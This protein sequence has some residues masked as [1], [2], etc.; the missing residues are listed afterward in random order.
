AVAHPDCVADKKLPVATEPLAVS[1]GAPT[2]PSLSQTPTT[3]FTAR[4]VT[5]APSDGVML[6]VGGL[7]SP[8]VTNTD[9]VSASTSE[10]DWRLATS[11]TVPEIAPDVG[12][13]YDT[14][15]PPV[16]PGA[17]VIE[18]TFVVQPF[19]PNDPH[20]PVSE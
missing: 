3:A 7:T 13:V 16:V 20:A 15:T 4:V 17:S 14:D 5:T 11:L 19:E 1:D 6:I 2:I 12:G 18:G 9:A 8:D 10:P